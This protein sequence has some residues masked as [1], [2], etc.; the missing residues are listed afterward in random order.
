MKK[1]ILITLK[2]EEFD[3]STKKRLQDHEEFYQ[4]NDK[5]FRNI[6]KMLIKNIEKITNKFT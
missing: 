3:A 6:S 4:L 2:I 1:S 5:H